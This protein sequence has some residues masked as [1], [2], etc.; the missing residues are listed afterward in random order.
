MLIA[1]AALGGCLS[2]SEEEAPLPE[3]RGS[4]E[5]EAGVA[6]RHA[7][8]FRNEVP[9][10]P[11]GSQEEQIA[12]TYILGHV[13]QAGYPA[14][15]DGVPVGNLVRS[16]NI[17][18]TPPGG[19]APRF[20]VATPYDTPPKEALGAESL[21]MF[22]ELA[23]ALHARNPDH[24]VA[25]V[26]LGAEFAEGSDGVRG[27]R[28]LSGWLEEGGY[29]PVIVYLAPEPGASGVRVSGAL[30]GL[31]DG[32]KTLDAGAVAPPAAGAARAFEAAGFEV[33]VVAGSPDE[34]AAALLGFLSEASG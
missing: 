2:P 12:A 21:G 8:E 27:S 5:I 18:A 17:I 32:A 11:A 29:E 34:V 14:R 31:L 15:L 25:F 4:P 28:A 13:Q 19:A 9:E 30:D 26:A 16:T 1:V 20:V 3:A 22:L 10:R 24:A 7:S 23:R 6:A 33:G